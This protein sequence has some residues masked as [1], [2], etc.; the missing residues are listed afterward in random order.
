MRKIELFDSTLRD[1]SQGEG[2]SFSVQDKLN[3]VR[4][5]DEFGVTYI[6]A[7]NPGSNPKDISFFEQLK[8]VKLTNATP[9]AFGSTTRHGTPAAEDANVK[10]LIDAGTPAVAVFG[11]SW[12]LH[13]REILKITEEDNLFIVKDTISCLKNAGKEVIFDA[14]HFFDGYKNNPDCAMSVLKAAVEGGADVLCLCDTNGGT[15]PDRIKTVTET[16]CEAFPHMRVAIHC[17]NDIGCAVASSMAAVEGGATQ[18][19][20]TL[21]GFGER[22]GNADLSNVLANLTLKCGYD[23]G[24]DVAKLHQVCAQVAEISNVRIVGGH[25][26]IGSSAFA[27]KGGM[28]IDGVQKCRESFEH[29]DPASVGNER[30]FLL[31]E[32][33][34]RGTVLPRLQKYIPTLTKSSPETIAVTNLL[35]QREYEGYQYEGAFASFELLVKKELGLMKPHFNVVM[36]KSYDDFPAPDGECQSTAMVKIEVDGKTELSCAAGNG[37][38]NAL[39]KAFRKAIRVFYPQIDRM[40]LADYKVRVI[41]NGTTD[42]TVRVLIESQGSSGDFTTIGVSCDIIEA[43]YTALIDSY[44]YELSNQ[45]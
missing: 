45:L 5:L 36:Y 14:E 7:G 12:D 43:S 26:Y 27:H 39:D 41:S 9:V 15:L 6:E 10:N 33:A 4:I 32:V 40:E 35:K 25:P 19:Q 28:H 8:S 13:I 37:P 17:H 18:V 23:C 1:G 2:I 42:A 31:S 30:K 34:G 21:I 29:I 11:K 44:E 20:G 16:V 3:I 22:C 38:V 24:V